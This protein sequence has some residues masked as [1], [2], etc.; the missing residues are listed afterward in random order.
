MGLSALVENGDQKH[1]GQTPWDMMGFNGLFR[2]SA[3]GAETVDRSRRSRKHLGIKHD[4]GPDSYISK[5][6]PTS[7]KNG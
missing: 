2:R 3:G 7:N 5:N 1:P 6:R 4:P